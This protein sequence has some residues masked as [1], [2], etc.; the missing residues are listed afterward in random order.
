MIRWAADRPA[1]VWALATGVVLAGAVAFTK[2]PLSAKGAMD[3]PKLTV[4]ASWR[5]A[6]PELEETYITS[7]MEAA[8][9]GVRGVRKSASISTG[10]STNIT[11]ELDEN[12][13]VTM[14]RLAILER[15]ETLRGDL[16]VQAREYVDFLEQRSGVRISAIGVGPERDQTVVVHDLLT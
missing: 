11:V 8:I 7:P 12:A 15:M 9:Q 3:L 13:D 16:P 4:N 5:G 2:L 1:V 14:A 10:G 6:S